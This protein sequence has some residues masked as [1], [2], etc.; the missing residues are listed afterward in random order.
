MK[1]SLNLS[2]SK[3]S[4]KN[5]L[6]H[7]VFDTFLQAFP[8]YAAKRALWELLFTDFSQFDDFRTHKAVTGGIG[9]DFRHMASG[10][11]LW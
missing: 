3:Q 8:L 2:K 5:Q 1:D 10:E 9:P 6:E 11:G 4:L 7:V